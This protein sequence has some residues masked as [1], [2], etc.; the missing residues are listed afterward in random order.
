M[1]DIPIFIDAFA[2]IVAVVIAFPDN[3]SDLLTQ[4]F[5]RISS[6]CIFL[7]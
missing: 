7:N 6:S 4:S 1:L 3:K 2:V 5:Y